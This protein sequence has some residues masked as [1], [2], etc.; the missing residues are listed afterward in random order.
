MTLGREHELLERNA[1]DGPCDFRI[2]LGRR[3]V[4]DARQVDDR[5]EAAT[6]EHALHGCLVANVRSDELELR[7]IER[8]GLA[9]EEKAVEHRD[10]ILG[11]EQ[12][13]NEHRADVSTPAGNEHRRPSICGHWHSVREPGAARSPFPKVTIDHLLD[14]VV[15]LVEPR[16]PLK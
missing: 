5:V 1:I 7:V 10:G 3:V 9:P 6:R 13:R 12:A 11:A 14:K 4:G 2:D 15:F 16:G 8:H